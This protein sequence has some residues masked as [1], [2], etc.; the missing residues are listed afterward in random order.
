MCEWCCVVGPCN[1]G[2][3]FDEVTKTC[4]ACPVGTYQGLDNQYVCNNCPEFR[5]TL[6]IGSLVADNCISKYILYIYQLLVFMTNSLCCF[7]YIVGH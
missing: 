3:Q 2:E 4:E 7:H 1:R 5:T 6:Q